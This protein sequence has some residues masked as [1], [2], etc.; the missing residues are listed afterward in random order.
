VLEDLADELLKPMTD[1]AE[2]GVLFRSRLDSIFA[3]ARGMLAG[4]G[5]EILKPAQGEFLIGDIP[6]LTMR[7]DQVRVGVRN[8]IALGDANTVLLPLGPHHLAALGRAD[9][10]ATISAD[11][12]D[13]LNSLQVQAADRYVYFRPGSGLEKY[14]LSILHVRTP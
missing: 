9:I 5:L 11:Q 2:S 10:I 1:A 13:R 12:V 3:Q 7:H 8:G 4:W 14:V 6:A